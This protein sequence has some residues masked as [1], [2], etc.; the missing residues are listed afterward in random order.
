M[1]SQ[2]SVISIADRQHMVQHVLDYAQTTHFP[3]QLDAA[4]HYLIDQVKHVANELTESHEQHL[5]S[6]T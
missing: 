2:F 3:E 1:D 5:T 4:I 6:S